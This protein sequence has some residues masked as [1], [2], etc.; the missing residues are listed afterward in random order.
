[1]D[2]EVWNYGTEIGD[3]KLCTGKLDVLAAFA[4]KTK[5]HKV[6]LTESDSSSQI[7]YL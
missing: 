1:M 5:G 7:G 4:S 6:V 2:F 3:I